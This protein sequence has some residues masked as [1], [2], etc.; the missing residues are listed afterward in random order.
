[1]LQ[2]KNANVR[3]NTSESDEQSDNNVN[4]R[5]QPLS[6]FIDNLLKM[7]NAKI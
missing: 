4:N 2:K 6:S 7:I 5:E 3:K 1:M